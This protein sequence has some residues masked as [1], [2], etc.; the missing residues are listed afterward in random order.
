MALDLAPC[1]DHC[2]T[3]YFDEWANPR[4]VADSAAVEVRE[5]VD[6]DVVTEVDI[7]DQS[8][9]RLVHRLTWHE[10]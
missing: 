4:S 9:R 10:Q 8:E 7:V 6:D 2:A 1:S 3:L 5:C